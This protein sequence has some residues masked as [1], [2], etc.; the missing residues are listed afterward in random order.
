[1]ADETVFSFRYRDETPD[2]GQSAGSAAHDTPSGGIG[3]TKVIAREIASELANVIKPAVAEKVETI[4]PP[5]LPKYVTPQAVD[6]KQDFLDALKSTRLNKPIVQ[7]EKFAST[8]T[9]AGQ[10]VGIESAALGRLAIAGGVA[11]AAI[12]ALGAVAYKTISRLNQSAQE[13]QAFSGRLATAFAMNEVANIRQQISRANLIGGQL[14]RFVTAQGKLERIA[15][16]IMA[17]LENA[18][19][20]AIIPALE[21]IAKIADDLEKFFQT[22]E[23]AKFAEAVGASVG[24]G[25]SAAINP[26]GTAFSEALKFF[27]REN[28]KPDTDAEMLG[29]DAIIAL[30]DELRAGRL[31]GGL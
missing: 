20:N 31:Q 29:V 16:R 9:K 22:N 25:V 28:T 21:P 17:L 26:Y 3:D 27:R 7:A 8:V 19:L 24:L 5:P 10:A 6:R 18:A 23:G 14:A 4:K 2:K 30:G 15:T 13:L 11:A 1:M 12:T